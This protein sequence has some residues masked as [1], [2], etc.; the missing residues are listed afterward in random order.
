[1]IFLNCYHNIVTQLKDKGS[2]E[3][4]IYIAGMEKYGGRLLIKIPSKESQKREA[5]DMGVKDVWIF[6]IVTKKRILKS[7]N[8]EIIFAVGDDGVAK[9]IRV[10]DI[11]MV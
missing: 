9:A 1:M 11:P 6:H 7:E 10:V 8:G 5:E 4:T 2:G 3:Y